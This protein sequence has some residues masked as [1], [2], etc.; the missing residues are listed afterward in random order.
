RFIYSGSPM[1]INMAVSIEDFTISERAG[2]AGDV[3]FSIELKEYRFHN[4]KKVKVVSKNTS[5]ASNK[6]LKSSTKTR[7]D[8]RVRPE[9]YTVKKGD[10]LSKIAKQMLGDSSRWKEIQTLNGLTN[11]QLKTLQI[12]T[13]LK[14]PKE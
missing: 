6:S 1:A 9:T 5:A 2:E 11:I 7:P 13:V 12:G 3:Y 10:T 4:A 8:M 14:L